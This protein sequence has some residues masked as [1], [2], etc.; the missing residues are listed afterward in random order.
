MTP[1]QYYLFANVY[2]LV[3]WLFYRVSLKKQAHF[4]SIRIYLN[5]AVIFSLLLPLL[6][7]GITELLSSGSA[8]INP[9]SQNLPAVGFIYSYIETFSPESA[10]WL[11][12]LGIL[13]VLIFSGAVI[14]ALFY[15]VNHF[16][17]ISIL[18]RAKE[19]HTSVSNLQVLKSDDVNIPF[20]YNGRIVLPGTI[21]SEEISLVIAHESLHHRYRHQLDNFLFSVYHIVFWINPFFLLLKGAL[22]L[23]H[24]Y[25]V[26]GQI[27]SSG[28]DPRFYKLSLIKYSVGMQRFSLASSLSTSG[29]KNRILMIN[30]G[31]AEMG[32]WRYFF[33][34]PILTIILAVFCVAYIQPGPQEGPQEVPQEVPRDT[35]QTQASVDSVRMEIIDVTRENLQEM[36]LE[37]VVLVLMNRNS[38]I[39]IAGE[40]HIV[41]G[42]AEDKI[43]SEYNK[44]IELGLSDV[45]VVVQKDLKTDPDE[46]RKLLDAIGTAQYKLRNIHANRLYGMNYKHLPVSEKE[47]IRELIPFEIYRNLPDKDM[48]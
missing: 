34:V 40:K 6:Q 23:N 44:I 30:N 1:I 47:M 16:R 26:D 14:T 17:I 46:F 38:R 21:S 24:E 3:F 35:P 7:N 19:Q 42:N 45:R 48:G 5:S 22:K 4:K 36:K 15:L 11:S 33:L 41:L 32:K 27:L 29:I 18:R 39:M 9:A 10:S 43:I 28:T 13:E 25:Q 2:I 8:I 20:I 12:W 37:V 31:Y